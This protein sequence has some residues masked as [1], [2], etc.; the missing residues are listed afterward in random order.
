LAIAT[1]RAI[2]SGMKTSITIGKSGRL[3]I[4]KPLRE[5]LGL[6]EG[7]R[8]LVEVVGGRLE[9]TPD[10]D[11]VRIETKKGIPVIVGGVPRKKGQLLAALKAERDEREGSILSRRK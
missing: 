6:R 9:A 10:S 7:S 2:F 11:A 5:R 8:L 4:P 1:F 3:V